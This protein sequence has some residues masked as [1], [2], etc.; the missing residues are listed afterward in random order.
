MSFF[1]F[2]IVL[3]VLSSA[4]FLFSLK[5]WKFF[6]RKS[7]FLQ[8]PT[9]PEVPGIPLIGNLLQLKERKPHKTFTK[10]A[11]IYGPIYS[12]KTGASKLIVISSS[13][14]AK[15]AMVTRFASISTRKLPRA[16]KIVSNDK[17]TLATSDYDDFHRM[18]KRFM[19]STLLSANAQK[20]SRWN[21]DTLVENLSTQLH[22]HA[23]SFP[24]Q[25]INFKK[26]FQ[27]ELFGFAMRQAFGRDVESVYVEELGRS[28]SRKEILK[29]LVLDMMEAGIEVDWRDFFPYLKWLPNK[30]FEIDIQEK[31]F[32]RFAV[33][34]ALIRE[35]K[36]LTGSG[37]QDV[38]GCYLDVLLSEGRSLTNEQIVILLWETIAEASDTTLVTTEWAMYEISKDNTRQEVLY[39][40]LQ[41]VCGIEKIKEEQ[42]SQLPYLNGVFHETLRKH[43]PAPLVPLRYVH[44][45]TQLG[46]YYIPS[47]CEIAINIYG[48]NMNKRQWESP[49]KWI[50]ERFLDEKF[51]I[52]DLQKTMAFGAGRR[53]CAGAL[54][55][56]LI[57]STAIGRLVQEFEW[58]L[59]DEEKEDVNTLG[60][61]SQKLHPL[62]AIIK[63]RD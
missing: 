46:G 48:C 34:N 49:E 55:A 21:R 36:E 5:R 51:N 41:S 44:E 26:L 10:W 38:V 50:P 18:A 1:I 12:I 3:G 24:D 57:A 60:L 22:A 52:I 54:Q 8:L 25:P 2:S 37:E 35:H 23:K 17:G 14:I 4:F 39:E 56:S 58:S 16:M 29:V 6:V 40:E 11:E 61:T 30:S 19:M 15:E 13:D 28:L 7:E 43:N 63:P 20:R 32:R 27:S 53:V 31:N 42:L 47:G 33:M 9:V 59:K 45:D 62:H